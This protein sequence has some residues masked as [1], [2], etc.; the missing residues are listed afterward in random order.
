M[1]L[2]EGFNE[3]EHLQD[4]IKRWH[5][6]AV[7]QWFKNQ[8]VNDI[9]T[10]KAAL[11]HACTIKDN[12]TATMTQIRLWLFEVTAGHAQSLQ[13]PIYGTPAGDYQ[14]EVTYKPQVKL[15]FREKPSQDMLD[16]A[17]PVTGEITF[18]LMA[19]TS[20][21]MSRAKA[22][23]MA[24]DIKREF[25]N[26]IFVWEKG[27]YKYTYKDVEKGYDLRLL[28]KSKAEGIRVAKA[29]LAIQGHAFSDDNQQFIEH[30][31]TYSLNPGT[32]T[33]YGRTVKKFV[34][35]PR[36]DVRFRYAQL[37]IHGQIN[38]VNLVAASDVGLKSVIE[39]INAA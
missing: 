31:R 25:T 1:P 21:T 15:F 14:R 8:A 6:K 20:Q 30:D 5:N 24:R 36:V 3:W 28:V 32:H 16:R 35:R 34:K 29:V 37:L 4:M 11:R 22:E 10:P 7:G 33:V 26:P 9:S 17:S 39:R 19:E 23:A 12:D 18:R 27:W 38:A 2:P 13:A